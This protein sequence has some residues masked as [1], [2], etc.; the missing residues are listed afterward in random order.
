VAHPETQ[1]YPGRRLGLPERGSGSVASWRRRVLAIAID[2]GAS[3]LVALAFVPGALTDGRSSLAD[4][5]LVPAIAVG[6]TTVLTALL[7]GSFGHVIC[8]MG[9][10]RLDGRPL[11]LLRPLARA[12]LVYLVIPPL[13]FNRDNR[14]LHD[15]AVGTVLLDR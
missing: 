12:V 14:G 4:L 15:L 10:V 7:G 13:V 5:V 11:G 1:D 9:V 6:Q 8:R 2:W 3:W